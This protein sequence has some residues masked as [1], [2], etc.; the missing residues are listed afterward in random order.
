MAALLARESHQTDRHALAQHWDAQQGAKS[1]KLKR[2]FRCVVRI[3]FNVGNVNDFSFQQGSAEA[4][5]ACSFNRPVLDVF[6]ESSRIAIDHSTIELI[7][8]ALRDGAMIGLAQPG[9]GAQQR[10]KYGPQVECRAANKL[11]HISGGSLLLQRLPQFV[12]QS[13]VLY[14][15]DRLSGKVLHQFD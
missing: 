12:E 8:S 11:E 10:V 5:V 7:A 15:D 13:R 3:G 6:Q 9:G 2:L 1:T 4:G 14:G